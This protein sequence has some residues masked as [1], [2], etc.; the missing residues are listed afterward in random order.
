MYGRKER[1][2]ATKKT[3]ED[4]KIRDRRVAGL[5]RAWRNP[6]VRARITEA[7]ARGLRNEKVQAKR[8]KSLSEYIATP[9]GKKVWS[10]TQKRIWSDKETKRNRVVAIREGCKSEERSK[11]ISEGNKRAWKE[12]RKERL[13]LLLKANSSPERNRK[14]SLA[15]KKSWASGK[16]KKNKRMSC[17]NGAECQLN[18]ILRRFFPGI[19]LFN[20]KRGK[21]IA[22]KTPDFISKKRKLVVEMFGNFWHGKKM[23]GHSERIEE[24]NRRSH[25]RSHGYTCVVIWEKELESVVGVVKKV[26]VALRA[27]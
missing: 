12:R 27:S 7:T 8:A 14:I 13:A 4:N 1:S 15:S 9:K 6:K 24:A 26:A 20:V 2:L 25:F 5:K 17:P 23:T 11:R 10:E 21:R 22:G 3:W 16:R 18:T 19:F